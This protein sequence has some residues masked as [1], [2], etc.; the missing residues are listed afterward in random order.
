MPKI[1]HS[2]SWW[3]D[4]HRRKANNPRRAPHTPD[5]DNPAAGGDQG[6]VYTFVPTR[7]TPIVGTIQ[8][9]GRLLYSS[10]E[11]APNSTPPPLSNETRRARKERPRPA[12]VQRAEARLL[13]RPSAD[14]AL[15]ARLRE[16][17]EERRRREMQE[18]L[19][20]VVRPLTKDQRRRKAALS[21]G[22]AVA[23]SSKAKGVSQKRPGA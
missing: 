11:P 22:E 13:S 18:Q 9:D 12:A 17:P 15:L 10:S 8:N 5:F 20:G 19:R 4:F 3:Q 23:S 2:A 7:A 16:K 14:E 21:A 1:L 6:Q